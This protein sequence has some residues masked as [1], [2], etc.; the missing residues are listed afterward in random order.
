MGPMQRKGVTYFARDSLCS[1]FDEC[2]KNEMCFLNDPNFLDRQVLANS[3]DPDQT[4]SSELGLHCMSRPVCPNTLRTFMVVSPPAYCF[5][6]QMNNLFTCI[7]L[8]Y[9]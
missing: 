2:Q 1:Y 8:Y 9:N 4:A 5:T 6:V 3:V 7:I